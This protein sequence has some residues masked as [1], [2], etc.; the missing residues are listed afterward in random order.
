MINKL[1]KELLI[2]FKLIG[3][4][5]TVNNNKSTVLRG[6]WH[7]NTAYKL[8]QKEERFNYGDYNLIGKFYACDKDSCNSANGLKY[9]ITLLVSLVGFSAF[10][11]FKSHFDLI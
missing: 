11:K 8:Y 1:S 9:P 7:E 5:F 3:L 2:W 10:F 4:K 6:C